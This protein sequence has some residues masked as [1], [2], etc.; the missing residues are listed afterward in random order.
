MKC[1]PMTAFCTI[2]ALR[3]KQ[4]HV[5]FRPSYTK[6][7]L[8]VDSPLHKSIISQLI[9]LIQIGFA[10]P[11]VLE[12]HPAQHIMDP[13]ITPATVDDYKLKQIRDLPDDAGIAR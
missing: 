8:R 11:T 1:I 7:E 10:K 5:F 9:R 12:A 2:S 13:Y 6:L 4:V 3:R